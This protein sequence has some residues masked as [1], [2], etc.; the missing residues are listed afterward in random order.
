MSKNILRTPQNSSRL[1]T[2]PNQNQANMNLI[3]IFCWSGAVAIAL[4]ELATHKPQDVYLVGAASS[5]AVTE[6]ATR[7]LSAE[8]LPA[9]LRED[10][11]L[12]QRCQA[13]WQTEPG[14]LNLNDHPEFREF[15]GGAQ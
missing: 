11:A 13:L 3:T 15:V 14:L 2:S 4:F 6:C 5:I 12:L 7:G 1:L 10:K 8:V 9:L